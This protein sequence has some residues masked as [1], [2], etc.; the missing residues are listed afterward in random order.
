MT[1]IISWNVNG[2]QGILKKDVLGVKNNKIQN[3]NPLSNMLSTESPDIICLQE[4]RCSEKFTHQSHFQ[5]YKYQ[6]VNYSKMRKGYSGTLVA[7]KIKPL[8]V[9]YDFE[10]YGSKC[11]ISED[12]GLHSEGRIITLEF[13]NYYLINVYTPN[14]GVNGFTRLEWRTK[15]WDPAFRRHIRKLLKTDKQVVIVGDLNVMPTKLD[16][17]NDNVR[18]TGST[19]EERGQ[20]AKLLD[21]GLVDCFR[22]TFPEKRRYTWTYS[23]KWSRRDSKNMANT[24]PRSSRGFRMDFTLVSPSVKYSK[25]R[26]LNYIGSDHFPVRIRLD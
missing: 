15:T 9:Y 21:L 4:I 3:E 11:P 10:L 24:G 18:V 26:V 17:W 25:S 13:E 5:N 6:Y 20:F 23:N 2:L 8:N 12:R 7:I 14:S 16:S 1:T 19:P 22:A